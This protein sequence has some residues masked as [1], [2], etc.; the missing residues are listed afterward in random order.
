MNGNVD[1]AI[2]HHSVKTLLRIDLGIT[3]LMSFGAG[4]TLAFLLFANGH[5]DCRTS[6]TTV[7]I[8]SM[9]ADSHGPAWWSDL[10]HLARVGMVALGRTM[11][12]DA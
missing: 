11:A 4:G 7:C 10:N 6:T 9:T 5:I 3:M 2:L 8:W 12:F 1:V